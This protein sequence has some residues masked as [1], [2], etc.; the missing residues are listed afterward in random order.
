MRND[1][2]QSRT[3]IDNGCDNNNDVVRTVKSSIW[4]IDA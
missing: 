3:S 4:I 2:N 1:K